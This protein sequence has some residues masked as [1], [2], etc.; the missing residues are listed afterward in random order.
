MHVSLG[1]LAKIFQGIYTPSV[2]HGNGI[3][4]QPSHFTRGNNDKLAPSVEITGKLEKTLLS[5]G[6]VLFTAK[7]WEHTSYCYTSTHY[8]TVPS[9]AFIVIRIHGRGSVLPEYLV[10]ILNHPATQQR[11]S[12]IAKGT[13]MPALS[14]QDIADFSIPVPPLPLQQSITRI[15]DLQDQKQRIETSIRQ[16]SQ[17]QLQRQLFTI[18]N[19]NS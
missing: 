12:A 10:W 18:A 3:L 14:L 2:A 16:A 11:L 6:D 19:Q 5:P 4:L 13:A 1:T 8:P 15:A 17:Q 7:G 9:S